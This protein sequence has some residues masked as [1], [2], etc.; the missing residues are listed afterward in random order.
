MNLMQTAAEGARTGG[1]W[2]NIAFDSTL[3]AAVIAALTKGSLWGKKRNGGPRPGEA[4]SCKEHSKKL[5][6]Q[7]EKI[8]KLEEW[9][10]GAQGDLAII[11]ADIKTLLSRVPARED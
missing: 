6:G 1:V 9:K 5:D 11:K 3:V 10:S 8:A 7:V 4:D 2:L